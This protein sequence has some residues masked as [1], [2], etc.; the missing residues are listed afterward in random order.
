[1]FQEMYQAYHAGRAAFDPS[2]NWYIRELAFFD[3][4]VIPLTK[5]LRDSGVF[6]SFGDEYVKNA[7]ENRRQW[8]LRG[9]GIMNEMLESYSKKVVAAQEDTIMFT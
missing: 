6:G 2:A 8:E 5:K 1:M 4:F 9:K 7:K 3:K